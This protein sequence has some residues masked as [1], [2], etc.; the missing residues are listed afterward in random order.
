VSLERRRAIAVLLALLFGAAMI[1]AAGALP[2]IQDEAYYWAWSRSLSWAYVDHP[3]AI[4]LVLRAST[5]LL[6]DGPAGLRAPGLLSAL[7]VA[8]FSI[9]SAR[10]LHRRAHGDMLGLL[11]LAGA[12]MFAIGYLPATPDPVQ[13]AALAIAA[14]LVIRCFELTPPR[15]CPPLAA[16]MLIA[17]GLI[18]HSSLLV[19]A[20]VLL[21]LALTPRGRC[22]L[23]ARAFQAGLFAG[24][25]AL[26]PWFLADTSFAYQHD[27]VLSRGEPRGLLA[28]PVFLGGI[29]LA[30]GPAGGIGVLISGARALK[31]K[32]RPAELALAL[33]A[34][35]LLIICFVPVLRGGGELNWSMPA[36]VLLSPVI[37]AQPP[38]RRSS[39][40]LGGASAVV[41]L[42]LLLHIAHPFLPIAARKD[43]T[44]RGAGFEALATA[45]AEM[46]ERTGARAIVTRRYQNASMMR[47]HLRDRWPVID[48]GAQRKSQY[49]AWP[50]P[51]LC[52]GETAVLVVYAPS[53]PVELEARPLE[54]VSTRRFDRTARGETLETFFL[55]PVRMSADAFGPDSRCSE[56][57]ARGP[58]PIDSG[59][60]VG[61]LC[62]PGPPGPDPIDSGPGV[63]APEGR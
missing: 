27:R 39:W 55:V 50:R 14:Y 28:V 47:Y 43:T 15:W 49:D 41:S 59:A 51:Q 1:G 54:D 26:I 16:F 35:G 46:A 32:S 31:D 7:I 52:A 30:L 25:I 34:L 56:I 48:L 4:A 57:S 42:V 36:L 58:D 45:A 11:L 8:G 62:R 60:G 5:S 33:G 20:F 37:A 21:G 53:V 24:A 9:A 2:A 22:L 13:G 23:K 17:G 10:R 18:K 44:Q 3:P 61:R 29:L 6:G 19:A 63:A 12:P 40:A 38:L